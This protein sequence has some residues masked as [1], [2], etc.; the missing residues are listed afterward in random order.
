MIRKAGIIAVL[1][2]VLV[3]GATNLST[4]IRRYVE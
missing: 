1:F 3:L 4:A 2:V